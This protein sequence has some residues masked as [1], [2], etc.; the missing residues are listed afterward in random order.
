MGEIYVLENTING[1][2][3]IGQTICTSER[4]WT[5]HKNN[6]KS[7]IGRAIKK[8]GWENFKTYKY[9]VP[10]HLLD[11]FEVEM[12]KKVNS[13]APNGYNLAGGGSHGRH[14]E[15]SKRKM[16]NSSKGK[17]PWNK[18]IPRTEETRKKLSEARKGKIPWIQGKKHSEETKAKISLAR[19]GKKQKI[20]ECPHCGKLGGEY[21]MNQWHFDNCKYKGEKK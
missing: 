7:Y 18:G 6:K 16:S 19:K 21:A 2:C 14:S 8:Y 11:Y 17:I 10:E 13:L 4:R 1:K 5:A 9:F 3:Y 20:V 12:I 15:E